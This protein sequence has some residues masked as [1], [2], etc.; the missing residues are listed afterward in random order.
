LQHDASSVIALESF[1]GDRGTRDVAA[2]AFESLSLTRVTAHPGMQA[3][4]VRL[5]AQG[6]GGFLRPAGR[7]AQ[8][9][10]LL[11]GARPQR[12]TIAAGGG[13]QGRE[14]IIRIH[15]GQVGHALLFDQIALA[16]QH[17]QQARNDLVEQP[18]QFIAAGGA[19]FLEN[20][21]AFG[22][23]IDPV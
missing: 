1:V 14:R 4:A 7:G 16:G 13:L 21:L 3:E 11:A 23:P 19:R 10:H 8:A 9:Q 22:A 6:R 17:S 12:N 18:R 2:Q 15:V 20:R 5:G